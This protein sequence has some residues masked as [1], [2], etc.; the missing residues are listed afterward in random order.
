MNGPAR[1]RPRRLNRQNDAGDALRKPASD[2][3]VFPQK[4]K[5]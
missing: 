4:R 1:P 5:R 3:T 2:A